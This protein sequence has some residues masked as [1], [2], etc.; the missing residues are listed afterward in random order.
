M[1]RPSSLIIPALRDAGFRLE[2]VRVFRDQPFKQRG[3]DIA[4]GDAGH[5]MRVQPLRFG[6]VARVQDARA[7]AL[8]DVRFAIAAGGEAE[9]TAH[10]NAHD[11]AHGK[12]RQ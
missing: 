12:N 6:A 2:C 9:G 10:D 7:I 4:L 1:V 8:H 3:D 5:H 11:N